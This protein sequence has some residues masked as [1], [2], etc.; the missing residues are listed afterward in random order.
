M[1]KPNIKKSEQRNVRVSCSDSKNIIDTLYDNCNTEFI[2][3]E[4]KSKK[5]TLVKKLDMQ[6]ETYYPISPHSTFITSGS[7]LFP[8]TIRD[9]WNINTLIKDI[10]DY[11]YKYVDIPPDFITISSYYV[12]MTY[13]Y[14]NFS[15][16]PYLRVIWDYGSGKSR[17]LKIVGSVC[18]IPM[19][20]NGGTSTSAIF[21]MIEQYKWTLILDEADFNFSDTTSDVIKLLNNGYQKWCP[22]I[23]A[24]WKNFE[25]NCYEVFCPKII[26][27]RSEFRDKATESR[28]LSHVMKRSN[29]KDLPIGLD[30]TFYEESLLLRN[31]LLQF[32]FDNLDN[33]KIQNIKIEGLEPRLNQ[34]INPMLSIIPDDEAKKVI[35]GSISKK[36]ETIKK[37]RKDSLF[38]TVLHIIK[39]RFNSSEEVYFKDIIHDM[40]KYEWKLFFNSRKLWAMLKK[41]SITRYRKNDGTVVRKHENIE[42]FTRL[43]REYSI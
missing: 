23:K 34:I 24:D 7:I 29:R 33:I 28:C 39:I 31:K 3:F 6:W 32:R 1:M 37:D 4:R 38:W 43:C 42:E 22:I 36:Q 41:N 26:W 40:E 18:Y 25:P 17:F 12:L 21:R 14:T 8:G 19:I 35:I 27:G 10:Q 13:I 20:T 11:I 5:I 30:Q 16:I 9:Y 2:V 15:E